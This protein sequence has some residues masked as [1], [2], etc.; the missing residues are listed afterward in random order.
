MLILVGFAPK[1]ELWQ[2]GNPISLPTA[3]SRP[4]NSRHAPRLFGPFILRFLQQIIT[5]A[6]RYAHMLTKRAQAQVQADRF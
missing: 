2:Q 1:S 6:N 4:G 5:Y 3:S